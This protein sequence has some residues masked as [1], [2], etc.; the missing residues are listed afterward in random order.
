MATRIHRPLKVIAFNANGI[1]R[2]R[3]ELSKELKD[4]H[5]N[6]AL[7]TDTHLKPHERLFIPNYQV[8]FVLMGK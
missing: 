2:K 3:Y 1:G 7:F 5:I 6:V 4:L 8:K